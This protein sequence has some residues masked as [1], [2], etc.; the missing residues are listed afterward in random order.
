MLAPLVTALAAPPQGRQVRDLGVPAQLPSGQLLETFQ[1][2]L[3]HGTEK[4]RRGNW[5][6]DGSLKF[7]VID[8]GM[9]ELLIEGS[10]EVK[11][12]T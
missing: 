6:F 4:N 1:H 8:H 9:I 10:L 11:G 3:G 2:N 5:M 7:L 12:P